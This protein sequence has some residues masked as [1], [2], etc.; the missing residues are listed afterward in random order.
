MLNE[1]EYYNIDGDV[2]DERN[3]IILRLKNELYTYREKEARDNKIREDNPAVQDAW[4]KYLT[5][6]TLARAD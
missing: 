2:I 3:A 4:V 5:V 1:G 6:L